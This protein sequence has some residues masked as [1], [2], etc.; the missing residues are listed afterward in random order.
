[1]R[2]WNLWGY[3][4]GRDGAQAELKALELDMTGFDRVDI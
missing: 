2:K 1:M 3:I 4:D